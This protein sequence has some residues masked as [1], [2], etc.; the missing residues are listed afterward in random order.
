MKTRNILSMLL[1][2]GILS[3]PSAEAQ[4]LKKI[5]D[6]ISEVA[7]SKENEESNSEETESEGNPDANTPTAEE[8]EESNTKMGNFFGGG[9]EGVPDTYKF[10]YALTYEMTSGKE[11][12]VLE[13]LLE[14]DAAYYGNK[15]DDPR[16]HQIIV[17]DLK[18]NLMV[19]F[20]ENDEQKM[21][22]KM[23]MPNMKKAEKKFGKKLFSEEDED[24][25][26]IQ[27][28]GK[29]I[30]GYQCSGFQVTSKD[31]IGKFW[32]TND[33]PVSLNGVYANFSSLPKSA[34]D[35]ALPLNEKSLVMEMV[36]TANK[37]K[38]DNMHMICTQLKENPL[39]INKKDYKAGM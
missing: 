11:T 16:A 13:Y 23:R 21:A 34:K 29:T 35:K 25:E 31:G 22:M 2:T 14:P 37:G 24:V 5:K 7:G 26:I 8:R 32:V 28:E 36:Y 30:L 12:N 17:Y 9:M 18:K 15:M 19:T 1:I 39:E 20:M 27:I 4:F 6:K 10:S 38:K 33:A 3:M